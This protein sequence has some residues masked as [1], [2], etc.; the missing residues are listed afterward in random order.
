MSDLMLAT[1]VNAQLTLQDRMKAIQERGQN[2]LEYVG[3]AL[4]AGI[5][6]AAIFGVVN[7]D[8]IGGAMEGAMNDI[9]SGK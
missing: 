3:I 5:V 9:F 6:V 4:I 1:Y 7:K 2:S 8:A